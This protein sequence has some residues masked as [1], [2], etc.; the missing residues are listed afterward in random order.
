MKAIVLGAGL[1][2]R[3][4]LQDI[5]KPMYKITD[6]PI[7]EH[8]ILL[9]RKHNVKDICINLHHMP[10]VIKNYFEDGKKFGVKIQYSF[11]EHL[12]GTSGAVKNIEWFWN[13]E[14]F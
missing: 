9:L 11:E 4:K 8:N 1:G 2:T 14:P 13:K 6:K 5:P 10:E 7:L 12:L 3:L